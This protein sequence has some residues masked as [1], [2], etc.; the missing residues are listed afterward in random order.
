MAS[1]RAVWAAIS[2][3]RGEVAHLGAG[4][5]GVPHVPEQHGVHVHGNQVGCQRLL[6]VKG[7]H[8]RAR[9]HPHGVR[10]DDGDGP[11]QP[12]PR[13]AVEA[14][15]AQHH[16]ALPLLGDMAAADGEQRR[17]RG[18]DDQAHSV[19]RPVA[20]APTPSTQAS[21]TTNSTAEN[22]STPAADARSPTISVDTSGATRK[23]RSSEDFS[24]PNMGTPS[25]R[26]CGTA[27]FGAVRDANR[28]GRR[29]LSRPFLGSGVGLLEIDDAGRHL[30]AL[31][32]LIVLQALDLSAHGALDVI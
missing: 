29:E 19:T 4:R 12:R 20:S 21:T 14:P 24:L 6:G 26:T 22:S 10:L 25:G 16:H 17:Q 23:R 1:R 9:V 30:A 13:H 27:S 2:T 5:G 31:A 8:P 11:E 28:D 18:H 32:G 15:E 3:A 7:R